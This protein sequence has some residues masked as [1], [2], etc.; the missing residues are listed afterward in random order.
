M[1]KPDTIYTIKLYWALGILQMCALT[2]G[3]ATYHV[4]PDGNLAA[5][6]GKLRPGDTLLLRD[7]I[8]RQELHPPRSG[9]KGRPITIRAEHDGGAVIDGEGKRAPVAIRGRNYIIIEGLVAR[10]SAD[11]NGTGVYEI[12]KGSHNIIRRCT[13]YDAGRNQNC[14]V[15]GVAYPESK[16]NLIEDC[17]AWGTGRKMFMAFTAD[18]TTFRRCF[19]NWQRWDGLERG[20][21]SSIWPNGVN[22][23]LYCADYCIIENC[24]GY[25][26]VAPWW[27]IGMFSRDGLGSCIGN[28]VLGSIAVNAGKKK[29]G[30]LKDFGKWH[31]PSGFHI[32]GS[33]PSKRNAAPMACR[34]NLFR[35]IFSAG[36]AGAGF[37]AST[38]KI[39]GC[40]VDRASI[41]NNKRSLW[42]HPRAEVAITSSRIEGTKHQGAGARLTHRYID[43][44][45]TDE[46]LWPWPMEDRI[47]KEMGIS[48]TAEMTKLLGIK[49]KKGRGAGLEVRGEKKKK[50]RRPSPASVPLDDL[51]AAVTAGVSAG[52]RHR[53][54]VGLGGRN[55]YGTVLGASEKGLKLKVRGM[56]MEIGWGRLSASQLAALG[57]K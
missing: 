12:F 21:R 47:R 45:L 16:H 1:T 26:G 35:D 42:I 23:E 55:V 40:T 37:A 39:L 24:I 3:A 27:S 25:G 48:V 7:G 8:Y 19:A 52:R 22:L 38:G 2:A 41:R 13:G 34:D 11:R 49:V 31:A 10:N 29:D 15:F 18:Y 30:T 17:A 6:L 28:K 4:S 36:N 32:M 5:A 9:E 56:A 54:L 44:I 51:R 43:G 14:G 50:A 46:P 53:V 20:G 33:N 57:K